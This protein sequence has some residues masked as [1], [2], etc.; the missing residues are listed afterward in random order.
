M[1]IP[2]VLR[3]EQDT[4]V[5]RSRISKT[6][7]YDLLALFSRYRIPLRQLAA[8]ENPANSAWFRDPIK[9]WHREVFG[10]LQSNLA[11]DTDAQLRTLPVVA[12]VGRR[13]PLR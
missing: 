3:W 7:L 1:E 6:S 4:L 2:G 10:A 9:Y 12:P 13:S 8:L 5:V 11:V